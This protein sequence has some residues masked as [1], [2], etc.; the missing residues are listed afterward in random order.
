MPKAPAPFDLAL[1][2]SLC[3]QGLSGRQIAAR[4]QM[5]PATLRKRLK[6]LRA[7]QDGPP[8]QQGVP[9]DDVGILQGDIGIP[10]VDVGRPIPE[11]QLPFQAILEINT[12]RFTG[13]PESELAAVW[14][15]LPEIV[16]WW[17]ARQK[18]AAE[19]AEKLAR[20]TYHVKPSLVEAVRREADLT[21]D[22]QADIVNRALSEYFQRRDT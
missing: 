13:L 11:E 18:L 14:P 6:R 10:D 17:Q 7:Q 3:T 15:V 12:A 9:E 22:S 8:E 4:M 20:T 5:P 19:P 2:D 1:Y 16:A 21:G